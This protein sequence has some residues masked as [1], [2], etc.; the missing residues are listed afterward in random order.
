MIRPDLRRLAAG[1]AASTLLLTSFLVAPAQDFSQPDSQPNSKPDPTAQLIQQA[2]DLLAA[3]DYSAALKILTILNA[4]TPDN[5]QILYDLGLATEALQDA[6]AGSQPTTGNQQPATASPE[7]YYRQAIAANPLLPTPHVALGLLLARTNRPAE[8]RAEMLLAIQIPDIP[9]A[10]KARADRAIARIDLNGDPQHAEPPNPA[11]AAD[12]LLAALQLTPEAP[13]DILLSAEIAEAARDLPAAEK[14]YR[15]YLALPQNATDPQ[16]IAALAHV[17]L[18]EHHP[19]EAES[20]LTPALAAHPADPTLTSQLAAAYLASGDDAKIAQ[21]AP[22]LESLH[23]ANPQD[24]NVT[25]LLARLYVETGHSDQ[26]DRLYATLI[27]TQS[28]SGT[29]LDPTLL[30]ERA[31]ALIR[32]HRPG[33]AESLL[34]QAVANP[35]GF[36]TPAALGDAALHL[37]FAAMEIDDPKVVLQA[38]T[39]RSTVLPPSPS[40]LFLEAT[41]DDTLHQSSKA[42]DLYRQFLA[43]AHGE[44]PQQESQARQ[45]LAALA[46]K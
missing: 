15:R 3:D 17:L 42:V 33:E 5:P 14:S 43:A 11:A 41:A 8:A 45:R 46:K 38:L 40:A 2:N 19:A 35:S 30:D 29:K 24:A 4:Q 6:P 23:K 12:A 22:L 36:P 13:E 9:A 25:R 21:A 39:L 26:A 27:S 31:E 1:L 16:A 28:Q 44:L 10:L 34:K 37:A 32:L 20:L 18:A 7:T